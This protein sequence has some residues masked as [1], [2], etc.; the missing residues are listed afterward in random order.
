MKY[1]L[2]LAALILVAASFFGWQGQSRLSSARE[3][4]A[5]LAGEAGELG[6]NTGDLSADASKAAV[7]K[8]RR[9]TQED[10]EA[11]AKDFAAKLIAFAHEMEEM[12]KQGQQPDPAMQKRIMDLISGLL[13]M[14]S[15]QLKLVVMQLRE[16]PGLSAEMRSGMVGFTVMMLANDHPA[17]AL[18]LLAESSDLLK[19]SGM[20][21][22]VV[23]S[24]LQKWAQSDPKAAIEWTRK[25]AKDHPE[26][27]TNETKKGILTGAAKIDP[28]LAFTLAE[29]LD[30]KEDGSALG[31]SIAESANT[32][33]QR[34]AVMKALRDH[35]KTLGDKERIV[36]LSNTLSALGGKV[37]QEGFSSGSAWLEKADLSEDE[38]E[39]FANGINYWQTKGDTGKWLE[40]MEGNVPAGKLDNKVKSLMDQWTQQDYKAAGQWINDTKEGPVRNAAI[41]SYASNVA[42]Y[43]PASAAEWALSLPESQERKDLLGNIHSQW[44]KKDANAAAKFA[45]ENGL[46]E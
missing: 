43:E 34:T 14:D 30:L 22:H 17:T 41:R 44:K 3:E 35:V 16:A 24:A 25:N 27:V 20:S 8:L 40:W 18:N 36:M 23:S 4:N 5:R 6:L 2:L 1:S 26:M 7:A 12:Q 21:R 31:N 28:A 33:E 19:E 45:R 10:K 46:A 13:D 38:R 15:S 42:P 11:V 32:A 37:A 39:G 29:E 9:T